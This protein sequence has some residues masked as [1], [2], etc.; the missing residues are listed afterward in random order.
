MGMMMI[1]WIFAESDV[2][3]WCFA[4]QMCVFLDFNSVSAGGKKDYSTGK[5]GFQSGTAS[6]WTKPFCHKLLEVSGSLGLV[7]FSGTMV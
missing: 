5:P 3:P 4:K 1:R 7:L 2:I 6:F